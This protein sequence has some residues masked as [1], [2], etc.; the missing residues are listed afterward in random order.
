[1]HVI[2]WGALSHSISTFHARSAFFSIEATGLLALT[3]VFAILS[4]F[5]GLEG[6]TLVFDSVFMRGIENNIGRGVEDNQ[7]DI[8][9]V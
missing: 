5:F 3:N 9:D 1:L 7:C 6:A 4:M 8:R 2:S